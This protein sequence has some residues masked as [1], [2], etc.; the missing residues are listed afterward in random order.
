M[1][2][3][4]KHY[5]L[6]TPDERFQLFV[7]AMGRKDEQELDRLEATCPRRNYNAQDS[8][9]TRKKWSFT[10][11]ALATALQTLRLEMLASTALVVALATKANS[12]DTA[13]AKA[14]EAFNI[15]IRLRR[16]KSEGWLQFC[17]G[18]GV[19]PNAMTAPFL[20]DV[21]W[22]MHAVEAM[23]ETL[24]QDIADEASN[25]DG[26]AAQEF[27]ALVNAWGEVA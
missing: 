18:L 4:S 3:I 2:D 23:S 7:E 5:A 11:L 27:E 6:L 8:E 21:E 19:N 10:V 22:A 12:N 9:Y 24:I 14:M 25:A 16:G 20:E 15:F 17:E 1:K 26:V 13:S